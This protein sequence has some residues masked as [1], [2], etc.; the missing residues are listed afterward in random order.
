MMR[1]KTGNPAFKVPFMQHFHS[2]AARWPPEPTWH[3]LPLPPLSWRGAKVSYA[4]V[5]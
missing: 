1:E 4:H 3:G 5:H 2:H